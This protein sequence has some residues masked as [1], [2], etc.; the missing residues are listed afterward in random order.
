MNLNAKTELLK[1]FSSAP[2]VAGLKSVVETTFA[3]AVM[4]DS[5]KKRAADDPNLS[6][7]G[8]AAYVAKVA[9]DNV[10]PLLEVTKAARKMARFNA[11]R[12]V[13]LKPATPPRDDIVGEMKRAELRAFIRS[14]DLKDRFALAAGYPDA[15]LDAPAA[16]SGLPQDR[17][18]AIKQ[19]FIRSKFGVEIAE[20]ETL[21]DDL[22]VV[23]AAHD[24]AI[25]E[26]RKNAGMDEQAFSKLIADSTFEMDGI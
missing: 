24:L 10:K 4:I 7:A 3:L 20:I 25:N 14:Q 23:R 15:V 12:K 1:R 22:A 13:S 26:L 11:D 19:D 21:D 18:E 9:V 17:Y 16:L 8:R 6:V 2:H 5:A